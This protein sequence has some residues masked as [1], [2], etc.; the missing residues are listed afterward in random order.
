VRKLLYITLSFLIVPLS[1]LAQKDSRALFVENQGQWEDSY[2]YKLQLS[3]GSMF[4]ENMGYTMLLVDPES[5]GHSEDDHNHFHTGENEILQQHSIKMQ[6]LNANPFP[7]IEGDLKT[8]F[9]YN[10]LLG[11]DPTHWK[12]NVGVY[13]KIIYKDIYPSIDIHYY[14]DEEDLKYDFIVKPGGDSRLIQMKYSGA[15]TQLKKD[16][17]HISTVF[18]DLQEVIPSVY[19]VIDGE[20]IEIDAYYELKN[21]I[22]Q[23]DVGDYNSNY[24]LIIDPKLVFSS[25]SGSSANNFGFTATYDN[26]GNSIGG[27]IVFNSGGTY[28][29]SVGAFQTSFQGA[30]GDFDIAIS[31]FDE[32]GNQLIFSTFLGGNHFDLPQSLMVDQNSNIY[33]LGAT[34]SNNF[35][36]STGAYQENFVGGPVDTAIRGQVYPLGTDAFIT[37]ISSDG[38]NLLAST[39][40]GGLGND[41]MNFDI[42]ENYGD[43]ARGEIIVDN[44]TVYIVSSS[45]SQNLM[46]PDPI[47]TGNHGKQDALIAS[48]TTD[49]TNMNWGTFFGG[50][51]DETGYALKKDQVGNLFITG[52]TKSDDLPLSTNNTILNAQGGIDGYLVKFDASNGALLNG[53]YIGTTDDDQSFFVDLDNNNDVYVLGQSKGSITITPDTYNN[54]NSQQ[55]IKKYDNKLQN[56]IWSTQIGSGRGKSD[57]VPTAFM[58]DDCYN[59]YLSGWNGDANKLSASGTQQGNTNGLPT[60]LDAFQTNTDG[61]DFYFLVLDRDAKSLVYGSYFGG[62]SSEHVDG[63][64]SRFNPNGSIYQAV[65]AGCQGRGFPTTPGAYAGNNGSSSGCNLGLIKFDFEITVRSKP[66]IDFGVDT[67]TICDSLI[68][69]FK[70]SSVNADTYQWNFGNGTSS[71]LNEP[72]AAFG[73]FGTYTIELIALDTNCGISD[74]SYLTIDHYTGRQPSASFTSNYLAC[75]QEFKASFDNASKGAHLYEWTFGDGN[76]SYDESPD[77]VF[78]GFGTYIVTLNAFDSLCLKFDVISDTIVFSDTT[79]APSPIAQ[80]AECGDGSVDIILLED[81][82]R[83]LYTWNFG[84]GETSNERNPNFFY[85]EPGNYDIKVTVEDTSCHKLYS[86]EYPISVENIGRE[87][88]IPNAFSPNGDGL[89]DSFEIFGNHCSNEDELRIFNRWG[90]LIYHTDNPFEEFWD[91]TLNNEP[92]PIGI[93]TYM[94]RNG[95]KVTKGTITVFR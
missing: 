44:S 1:L 37:C 10:Y 49:L 56:E 76:R 84:N 87:M 38:T 93:Y 17:L 69:K 14:G 2:D 5:V 61:S 13:K 50:S 73:N 79:I 40:L 72:I 27:G 57:L 39:Y 42:G 59:I 4:F 8:G 24:D 7:S 47:I 75:D 30:N 31:K 55:Y 12:S 62:T 52:S 33:M 43:N 51:G 6:F 16:K 71:Q 48:L 20:R 63:G 68:L 94:I 34:G 11:N 18:G 65:C 26:E 77:Y 66:E 81:R 80:I 3:S 41:G 9:Y 78:P 29:T 82:D 95:K 70:N 90:D 36:V 22:V 28:P 19:Q 88:F 89:N 74:T 23:F 92:A 86:F 64:T 85:S 21:G 83:Y 60:T 67:D 15:Q 25:F 35:P 45:S 32:L 58:V 91:A 54:N 46:F 53:T